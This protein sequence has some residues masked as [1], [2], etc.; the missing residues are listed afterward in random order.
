MEPSHRLTALD[1]ALEG[2]R[3]AVDRL[4]YHGR[5]TRQSASLDEL[6]RVRIRQAV[7][8]RLSGS[9]EESA[10]HLVREARVRV[11]GAE[12]TIPGPHFMISSTASSNLP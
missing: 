9:A 2:C 11:V 6:L 1:A 3:R 12:I 4:R 10:A 8:A 7:L 5:L